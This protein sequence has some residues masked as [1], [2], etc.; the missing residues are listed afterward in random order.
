MNHKTSKGFS[1][2]F[3]YTYSKV[4][5]T[6][7]DGWYGADGGAPEVPY[8]L[9]ADRSVAGFDLTHILS[10]SWVYNVPFGKGQRW[11][12]DNKALNYTVGN[13]R[14][15]GIFFTSSGQPFNAGGLGD[16]A[17]TGNITERA[18]RLAGVSPFA[19]K[20]QAAPDGVYWL[21]PAAFQIPAVFTYGTEGRNDLRE[22]WPRNFDISLFRSFPFT[23]TKNLEFDASSLM[24]SILLAS[25]NRTPPLG[26]NTSARSVPRPTLHASS[27]SP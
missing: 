27:S 22:D 19:N 15:N 1:Y 8:T 4:I 13:W 5:N 16:I 21:N 23:E 25:V 18:D 14:L 9:S 12:S 3:S 2:L 26:I 11:K 24:R 20:G 17:N 10:F 7:T 6:G